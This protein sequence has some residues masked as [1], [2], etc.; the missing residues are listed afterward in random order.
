MLSIYPPGEEFLQQGP[1][2]T[3]L[4]TNYLCQVLWEPALEGLLQETVS[5]DSGWGPG[6]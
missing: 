6:L 5:E 2:L 4:S 1:R 3:L